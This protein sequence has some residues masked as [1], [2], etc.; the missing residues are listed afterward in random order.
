M[1]SLDD[2]GPEAR[3]RSASRISVAD[4]RRSVATSMSQ[5]ATRSRATFPDSFPGD[6]FSGCDSTEP[7]PGVPPAVLIRFYQFNLNNTERACHRNNHT[8]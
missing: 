8:R 4:A 1:C 2:G 6:L 7:V 5:S 3:L